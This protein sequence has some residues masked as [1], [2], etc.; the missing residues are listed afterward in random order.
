MLYK[1]IEIKEV[2]DHFG[3]Q[4]QEIKGWGLQDTTTYEY[5]PRTKAELNKFFKNIEDSFSFFGSKGIKRS[6]TEQ[7]YFPTQFTDITPNGDKQI[8]KYKI[9]IV[10]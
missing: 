1:I 6:Y 3:K 10:K 9:E 4:G 5:E 7:G 8:T 2:Y